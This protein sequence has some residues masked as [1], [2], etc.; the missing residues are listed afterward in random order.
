MTKGKNDGPARPRRELLVE[1]PM[2]L[3]GGT[4]ELH[5]VTAIDALGARVS[6]CRKAGRFYDPPPWAGLPA[7]PEVLGGGPAM[8]AEDARRELIG[9]LRWGSRAHCPI[10][11]TE[12]PDTDSELE[13]LARLLED[14]AI[15]VTIPEG[16]LL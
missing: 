4:H 1:A 9:A 15:A 16:V 10:C 12:D 5:R 3:G 11:G 14:R 13:R 6:W 7:V 2:L 8:N